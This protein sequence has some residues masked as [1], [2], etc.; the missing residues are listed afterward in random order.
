MTLKL[1]VVAAIVLLSIAF[2]AWLSRRLTIRMPLLAEPEPET[3]VLS[4][5]VLRDIE[6]VLANA[7]F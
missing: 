7:K 6:E 4:P 1:A 2:F 5:Q 3:E